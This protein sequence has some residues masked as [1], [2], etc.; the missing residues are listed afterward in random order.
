M[1]AERGYADRSVAEGWNFGPRETGVR[2]VEAL[3][4]R[5]MAE[6]GPGA[7]W[8]PDRRAH[9]HEAATLRLDSRKASERL[10]WEP[11][12]DFDETVAWTARWYAAFAAG[13]AVDGITRDQVDAFL[14]Q[15]VRL[16]SPFRPA[17]A[18]AAA[19]GEEVRRTA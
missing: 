2:D 7:R 6:W 18:P 19:T 11:L 17:A 14:G 1:L 10:G 4:T 3:V 16:T 15:R 12:L 9:P 13:A 8:I 5:F